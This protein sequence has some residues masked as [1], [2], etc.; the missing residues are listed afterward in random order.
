MM[1]LLEILGFGLAILGHG[2]L[3]VALVNRLHAIGWSR[4]WTKA[5]SLVCYTFFWGLLAAATWTVARDGQI[6][7]TPLSDALPI[8]SPGGVYF[9][10]CV[11]AGVGIFAHWLWRKLTDRPAPA[12]LGNQT[13]VLDVAALCGR[14]LV[15]GFRGKAYSLVPGN[16]VVQLHIHEMQLAVARLPTALQGLSIAHLSD[17]HMTG[18][19]DQA[20]FRT[21]VERTLALNADLIV[22]AGDLFDN[23]KCLE[24]IPDTLGR[25]T[26][27][28]GVYFVLGNHDLR[29]HD[30]PRIRRE[31]TA[32]GLIDLGGKTHE[33]AIGAA[34]LL[35]AGNEMP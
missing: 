31:L 17:L 29:L 33:R 4:L 35:L 20:Y 2:F 28:L 12:V 15:H 25:L 26:A 22:I 5:I 34:R 7:G 30:T 11:F 32:A 18:Q 14:S 27:R 21:L 13:E 24:W 8:N 3:W 10:L 1:P 9:G 19:V 16:Q 6:A 23:A